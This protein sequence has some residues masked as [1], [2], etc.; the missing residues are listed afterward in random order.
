MNEWTPDGLVALTGIVTSLVFAYFPKIKTWFGALDSDKKPLVNL[1]VIL[2]VTLGQLLITC[3]VV[4]VCLQ[5]QAPQ[6]VSTFIAALILNQ[7]TYL[8]AVRQFKQQPAS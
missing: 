2:A 6:A 7:T 3:Q 8:V 4:V 1:L 5:A